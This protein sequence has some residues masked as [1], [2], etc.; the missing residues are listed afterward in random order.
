[1]VDSEEGSIFSGKE[2]R[3]IVGYVEDK[4]I[5]YWKLLNNP[6]LQPLV[7]IV[8]Q[9][10]DHTYKGVWAPIEIHVEDLINGVNEIPGLSEVGEAFKLTNSEEQMKCISKIKMGVLVQYFHP[11][12]VSDIWQMSNLNGKFTLEKIE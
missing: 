12:M 3:I 11:N 7:Y 6:M 4:R 8:E 1:M 10:S 2:N 5:L 9:D